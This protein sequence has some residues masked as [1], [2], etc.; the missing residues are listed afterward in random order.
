[1]KCL[2][3]QLPFSPQCQWLSKK[4][5]TTIH[6]Q[7]EPTV[8]SFRAMWPHRVPKSGEVPKTKVRQFFLSC[9]KIENERTVVPLILLTV[10][11]CQHGNVQDKRKF[12]S[13]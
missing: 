2:S 8:G 5:A 12:L 7:A 4:L 11:I 10:H 13:A 6:V 1:M 3:Y 9:S